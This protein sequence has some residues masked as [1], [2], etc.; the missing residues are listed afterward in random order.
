MDARKKHALSTF[1]YAEGHKRETRKSYQKFLEEIGVGT[2]KG[3]DEENRPTQQPSAGQQSQRGLKSGLSPAVEMSIEQQTRKS[4]RAPVPKRCFGLIDDFED[5]NRKEN[6]KE[7]NVKIKT[8]PLDFTGPGLTF[9][10]QTFAKTKSQSTSRKEHR[11]TCEIKF[12]VS[13]IKKEPVSYEQQSS[14]DYS[15]SD[16]S[17]A[18]S[19]RSGRTP[20][21][22]K[23]FSLIEDDYA[24]TGK[25][26]EKPVTEDGNLASRN[27]QMSNTLKNRKKVPEHENPVD[28]VKIKEEFPE[29]VMTLSAS[30]K[31]KTEPEE[32]RKKRKR[33]DP[34]C[35]EHAPSFD[36]MT[37]QEP[38]RKKSKRHNSLAPTQAILS[39]VSFRQQHNSHIPSKKELTLPQ[40]IKIEDEK[41]EPKGRRSKRKMLAA[42]HLQ[43][44]LEAS[45]NDTPE[46]LNTKDQPENINEIKTSSLSSTSEGSEERPKEAKGK[47]SLK[48]PDADEG[49]IDRFVEHHIAKS[50]AEHVKVTERPDGHIILK[51]EGLHSPTKHKKHKKKHHHHHHHSEREFTLSGQS[52][53]QD[54]KGAD[55]KR[56]HKESAVEDMESRDV[57]SEAR[58]T[59]GKDSS[60]SGISDHSLSD[61]HL[62]SPELDKKRGKKRKLSSSLSKPLEEIKDEQHTEIPAYIDLPVSPDAIKREADGRIL[63]MK[64]RKV[65]KKKNGQRILLRIQTE[66]ID[67]YGDVVKV[68]S[69]EISSGKCDSEVKEHISPEKDRQIDQAKTG[70]DLETWS[71]VQVDKEKTKKKKKKRDKGEKKASN[72]E[73]KNKKKDIK[74]SVESVATGKVVPPLKGHLELSK[75]KPDNTEQSKAKPAAKQINKQPVVVKKKDKK[76]KAASK[77]KA[78]TSK[79]VSGDKTPIDPGMAHAEK[80]STASLNDKSNKL[81]ASSEKKSKSQPPDKAPDKQERSH[82]EPLKEELVVKKKS[83]NQSKKKDRKES[84]LKSSTQEDESSSPPKKKVIISFNNVKEMHMLLHF[85]FM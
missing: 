2:S 56:K 31:G 27:K 78:P 59:E 41:D 57:K 77:G 9:H 23:N 3:K 67:E 82:S 72:K 66:Y 84:A 8:E 4:K 45:T 54:N 36:S 26:S 61:K 69:N 7:E 12:A 40:D 65:Y 83:N 73:D 55:K 85:M 44:S 33:N 29:D 52:D 19:R 80:L 74:G 38:T 17:T 24:K 39:E 63:K 21:P 75:G 5:K 14:D 53:K 1:D 62:S 71:S 42:K 6:K 32:G 15:T 68:D 28:K 48:I 60:L 13:K 43:K 35:K 10:Q 25:K 64:K 76:S 70:P 11:D 81:K 51:V 37:S 50:P 18:G 47:F 16:S 20:V 58:L 49:V 30:N 34:Q 46:S 79:T 22:K